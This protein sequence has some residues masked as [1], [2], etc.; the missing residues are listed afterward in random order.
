MIDHQ[1]VGGHIAIREFHAAD[2]IPVLPVAVI[3][4]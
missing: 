3:H 1:I 4:N 2:E